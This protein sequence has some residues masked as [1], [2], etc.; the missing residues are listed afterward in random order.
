MTIVQSAR[1][2]AFNKGSSL[3]RRWIRSR[4][5]N[6]L[7]IPVEYCLCRYEKKELKDDRLR[8][9]I[10]E[11]IASQLNTYLTNVGIANICLNQEYEKTLDAQQLQTGENT[12]LYSMFVRLKPMKGDFTAEVLGTTSGF[13]LV[14]G[15]DRWDHRKRGHCAPKVFRPLCQCSST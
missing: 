15:F 7:P 6:N 10:G 2:S 12:T 3:L 9:R 1:G 11:F 4:T 14:S 8:Q 5:C 13:Q